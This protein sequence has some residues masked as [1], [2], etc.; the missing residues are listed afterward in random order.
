MQVGVKWVEGL[1]ERIV[2]EMLES[3]RRQGFSVASSVSNSAVCERPS[4]GNSTICDTGRIESLKL[5]IQI[6]QQHITFR[7]KVSF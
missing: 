3:Q 7:P 4:R 2:A 5:D 1:L 6:F